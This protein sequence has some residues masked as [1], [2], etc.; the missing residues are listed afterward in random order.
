ML[1]NLRALTVITSAILGTCCQVVGMELAGKEQREGRRVFYFRRPDGL[2]RYG[3]CSGNPV[4]LQVAPR[5]K[6]GLSL[7]NRVIAGGVDQEKS[8]RRLFCQLSRK[9]QRKFIKTAQELEYISIFRIASKMY[10]QSISMQSTMESLIRHSNKAYEALNLGL[11]VEE[12]ITRCMYKSYK[13]QIEGLVEGTQN[14]VFHIHNLSLSDDRQ[15]SF[16]FPCTFSKDLICIKRAYELEQGAGGGC[17]VPLVSESIEEGRSCEHG[18]MLARY[19]NLKDLSGI[20]TFELSPDGKTLFV[21]SGAGE[22]GIDTLIILHRLASGEFAYKRTIKLRN[23]ILTHTHSLEKHGIEVRHLACNGQ[24]FP[25]VE[26]LRDV[27]GIFSVRHYDSK[28]A[29]I[30]TNRDLHIVDLADESTL[31]GAYSKNVVSVAWSPDGKMLAY[32]TTDGSVFIEDVSGADFKRVLKNGAVV[33]KVQWSAKGDKILLVA[34]NSVQLVNVADAVYIKNL[35]AQAVL[36]AILSDDATKILFVDSDRVAVLWDVVSN[37]CAKVNCGADDVLG[38]VLSPDACY[39]ALCCKKN[40]KTILQIWDVKSGQLAEYPKLDKD[41]LSIL[42]TRLKSGYPSPKLFSL[43]QMLLFAV[44]AQAPAGK[45]YA[46][47]NRHFLIEHF[48]TLAPHLKMYIEDKFII[49]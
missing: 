31:D 2:A 4:D 36:Q 42:A 1:C 3:E 13:H 20:C 28:I 44:A 37:R 27:Q 46:L 16:L 40:G 47:A 39:A 38:A 7:I 24:T 21:F 17:T 12:A 34:A 23:G 33:C 11:Y 9:E 10:A 6:Y 22:K 35:Q 49:S 32:A 43:P 41:V 8:V 25:F 19:V 26:S 30:D 14:S 29:Y 5:N 45:K 15:D 48:K 18:V